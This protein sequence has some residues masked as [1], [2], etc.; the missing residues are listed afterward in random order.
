M[1][2]TIKSLNLRYPGQHTTNKPIINGEWKWKIQRQTRLLRSI[3][4][5]MTWCHFS[6]DATTKIITI[7]TNW[8]E[9]NVACRLSLVAYRITCDA[10]QGLT[11]YTSSFGF[12]LIVFWF[13]IWFWRFIWFII[14]PFNHM[15]SGRCLQVDHQFVNFDSITCEWKWILHKTIKLIKYGPLDSFSSSG[16]IF[17]SSKHLNNDPRIIATMR[18][19]IDFSVWF[20]FK[21][22]SNRRLVMKLDWMNPFLK[23]VSLRD[24]TLS[25][26]GSLYKR[27]VQMMCIW[28]KCSPD[29]LTAPFWR[30][31][32][33][34]H[35]IHVIE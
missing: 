33:F 1:S 5:W 28:K 4:F 29:D 27:C 2:T 18:K 3:W 34:L 10:T 24:S 32:F 9:Q 6:I 8:I 22:Q 12:I 26:I 31:K 13:A 14:K 21:I 7:C 30:K 15:K 20:S 23:K 17:M 35:K 11:L 16:F 25:I 19:K